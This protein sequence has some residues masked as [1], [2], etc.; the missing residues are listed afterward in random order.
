MS[1]SLFVTRLY[2]GRLETIDAEELHASCLSIAE[3]DEAGQD[4]CDEKFFA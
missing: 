3:D 2:Q 4:W 1:K